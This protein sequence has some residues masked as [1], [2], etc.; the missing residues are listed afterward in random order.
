MSAL[1]ARYIMKEERRTND[2]PELGDDV[3]NFPNDSCILYI[4]RSSRLAPS[5]TGKTPV[6]GYH[7][8]RTRPANMRSCG[9]AELSLLSSLSLLS[10]PLALVYPLFS[11]LSSLHITDFPCWFQISKKRIFSSVSCF[12]AWSITTSDQLVSTEL[13]TH[14][15]LYS[16]ISQNY[17]QRNT[18]QY[19]FI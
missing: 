4:L 11:L 3:R 2:G 17:L 8:N 14:K 19:G 13:S 15:C 9:A 18:F 1:P 10:P 7:S 16:K 5:Y 12:P 6:L